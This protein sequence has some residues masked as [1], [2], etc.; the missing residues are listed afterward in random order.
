MNKLHLVDT[1]CHLHWLSEAHNLP[2]DELMANARES[3]VEHFLCVAI[4]L[5]DVPTI[6][7][8]AEQYHNVYASVGLHP[9][10]LREQEP[11]MAELVTMA[12]HPAVIAIGETGLDYYRT[13]GDHSSQQARFRAHIE[14]AKQANLP[15]IIHTR[16]AREDTLRILK[17]EG[18]DEVRGVMHC[19]T[20]D[21]AMAEQAMEL[22]F[23]ISLAGIVTFKNA[24]TLHE[25]AKSVPLSRL[26]LET[27]CPYL[28]PVPFRGKP[29]QPAYVCYVAEKIAEL[30]NISVDEVAQQTTQ[31]FFDLFSRAQKRS[32]L[33][34]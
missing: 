31:N 11:T 7:A 15:L 3:G 27:D 33:D 1:H 6:L 8:L 5:D 17:E 29:N 22:G 21:V 28:A 32:N 23:Y 25:V 34:K 26:L 10:E 12:Q 14:A 20:E 4:T 19:F 30:K 13:Q 2:L 24:T 16:E 18:A 9:N